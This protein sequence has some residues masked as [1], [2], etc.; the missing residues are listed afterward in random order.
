MVLLNTKIIKNINNGLNSILK[1]TSNL[2]LKSLITI[3]TPNANRRTK[4][5]YENR[6]SKHLR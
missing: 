5:S 3:R 4:S 6:L 2:V 1:Y